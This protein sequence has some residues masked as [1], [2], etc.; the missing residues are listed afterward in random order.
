MEPLR[1]PE[2]EDGQG[3]GRFHSCQLW[4]VEG[5]APAVGAAVDK[6]RTDGISSQNDGQSVKSQ[7]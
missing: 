2:L 4:P 6:T 3:P 5:S 7:D 1:T